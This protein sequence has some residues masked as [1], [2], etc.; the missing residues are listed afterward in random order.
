[1][2]IQQCEACENG[3]VEVGTDGGIA[4]LCELGI[5]TSTRGDCPEYCKASDVEEH[6][7]IIPGHCETDRDVEPLEV[8]CDYGLLEVSRHSGAVLSVEEMEGDEGIERDSV[9]IREIISIDPREYFERT[10]ET[11]EEV[12]GSL[13]IS[14]VSF[15][16]QPYPGAELQYS[17]AIVGIEAALEAA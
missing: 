7:T 15:S 17:P 11:L 10:G 9:S 6:L 13:H 5:C 16:Y 2:S 14:D 1:M 8:V 12:V 3:S 4:W